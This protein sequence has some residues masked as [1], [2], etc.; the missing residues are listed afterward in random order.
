[1]HLRVAVESRGV[2]EEDDAGDHDLA[3]PA[4]DEEQCREHDPQRPSSGRPSA[5]PKSSTFHSIQ[6]TSG[7]SR[8]AQASATA[9]PPATSAPIPRMR[10]TTLRT[11]FT[12]GAYD[13]GH[14]AA[15]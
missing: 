12:R 13:G 15:N 3:E 8:I 2:D 5:G 4:D 11:G 14:S 10:S 9:S 1:V 7:P 6:K